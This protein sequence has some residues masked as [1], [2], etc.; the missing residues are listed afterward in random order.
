M[1]PRIEII[2]EK[3]MIGKK[4]QMSL[5]VNKTKELWQSFMPER[6]HIKNSVSEDL[7]SIQVYDNSYFKQFSP[8]TLFEKWACME[9]ADFMNLPSDMENFILP[10]GMYAVFLYKGA[11]NKGAEVFSYIFRK[12]LPDSEY[13]V[14][15][16]PHFEILGEK[17]K[18]EDPD[19]EE[20][21]WIPIR[22]KEY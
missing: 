8:D 13:L 7:Y 3:K 21:I 19:S 18:N 14:D 6:K 5:S 1:E 4:M 22:R 10:S 11:S 2:T 15:N 9:V 20:E 12:W 17:Y 16:R